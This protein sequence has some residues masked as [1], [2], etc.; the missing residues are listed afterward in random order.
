MFI[1]ETTQ[2][3]LRIISTGVPS[4][5]NGISSTGTILETI[6]L[7]PCLPAILSQ[8]SNFLVAATNT[9]TC[10]NTQVGRLS[11]FSLFKISTERTLPPC[12]EGN[13]KEESLT[14]FDLSPN[15]ALSNLSSG[16]S[17]CSPFG[18]IFQHNI[19]HHSTYEPILTIQ[20]TSRSFNFT[21]DTFGISSVI[22]SGHNLVS[23]ISVVYSL[24]CI[25]VK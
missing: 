10:A 16:E 24:I 8:S 21:L 9:L 13:L 6:H 17:S 14:S 23:L 20:S 7:L 22:C 4:S 3:G 2:S 15:I 19:E 1:L 12:P 5:V 11:Q 18:V 25:E